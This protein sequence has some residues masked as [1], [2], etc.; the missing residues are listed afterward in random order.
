MTSMPM[1]TLIIAHLAQ[2]WGFWIL[3][4]NMPT[5]LNYILKFDI[6]SVRFL[7]RIIIFLFNIILYII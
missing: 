3:V 6:K 2:N 7:G 4:T 5:Y 1:W